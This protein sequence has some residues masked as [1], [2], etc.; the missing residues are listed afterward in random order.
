MLGRDTFKT[1]LAASALALMAGGASAAPVNC[2]GTPVIP[3][4]AVD[5]EFTVDT[6]PNSVCFA[7]GI[8]NIS[9]NSGGADPDPLFGLL[10]ASFGAGHLLIDK[11]DDASSGL[12]PNAL[13]GGLTSGLIGSWSFVLP[14]AGEGFVWTNVI[15]AFK[16]GLGGLDPDWAA[17]LIPNGVTSGSW[18]I[19]GQQAL[20]HANLYAQKAPAPVPLPAAGFLLI[21]ALGGLAAVRRRRRA[22]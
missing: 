8:G 9:G 20:S 3:G 18:A 22:I 13:S 1:L 17:F 4:V 5:R 15:L 10:S 19:S 14:S 12:K 21:G 6:T 7:T 16:T 11:S 2:P